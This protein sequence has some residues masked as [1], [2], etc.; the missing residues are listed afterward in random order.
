MN[1]RSL[2]AA[3]IGAAFSRVPLL[4][5]PPTQTRTY[6]EGGYLSE[7]DLVR[8]LERMWDEYTIAPTHIHYLVP[9][10]PGQALNEVW[11]DHVKI[12]DVIVDK[13]NESVRWR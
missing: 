10:L 2:L 11:N 13:W 4:P 9:L 7:G 6:A 8:I 12:E 1:R 5:D 3:A